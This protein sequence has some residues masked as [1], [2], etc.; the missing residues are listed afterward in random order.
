M[1]RSQV[2]FAP[3]QVPTN[4]PLIGRSRSISSEALPVQFAPYQL[5][6]IT[7]SPVQTT[8]G[9]SL[10]W[11]SFDLGGNPQ[12]ARPLT[13]WASYYNMRLS[14][15]VKNGYALL[16]PAGQ[17]LGPRLSHEDWCHAAMQGSVQVLENGKPQTYGYAGLGPGAQVNCAP[18]F[19]GLPAHIL[20]GTN[21]VRFAR[22]EGLYGY[23]SHPF[24]VV[25][26]RTIAVDPHVIPIGA[27][28]FIPAAR[29]QAITLPS[30]YQA[31]HDGFFFESF[32]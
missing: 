29:G 28:V 27:V 18:F 14:R 19:P 2:K 10:P 5:S 16:D 6:A 3:Y 32:K 11:I 21:R 7:P 1:A 23:G 26:Y 24:Q 13:L 30:G 22:R 15:Q 9:D 4:A 31:V 12:S 8:L 20:R 17:P 25:P